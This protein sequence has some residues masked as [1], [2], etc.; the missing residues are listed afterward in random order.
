VV[1]G[2]AFLFRAVVLTGIHTTRE[3][4]LTARWRQVDEACGWAAGVAGLLVGL[5]CFGAPV[6][7]VLCGGCFYLLSIGAVFQGLEDNAR[8]RQAGI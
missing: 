2:A 4:A 1:L 3:T 8:R 6:S 5:L 7:A